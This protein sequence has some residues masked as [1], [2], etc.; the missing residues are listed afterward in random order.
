MNDSAA[1]S[2]SAARSIFTITSKFFIIPAFHFELLSRNMKQISMN[3]RN[4]SKFITL[5]NGYALTVIYIC[6]SHCNDNG[7][8]CDKFECGY[9][10]TA[11]DDTDS[12]VNIDRNGLRANVSQHLLNPLWR[13]DSFRDT[14]PGQ[15][16]VLYRNKLQCPRL[17]FM[18]PSS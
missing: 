16:G 13:A 5:S 7:P 4:Y 9:V 12:V 8:G 15:V 14:Q 1:W 3:N 18:Y 10:A 11:R 2:Q 6:T 17:T